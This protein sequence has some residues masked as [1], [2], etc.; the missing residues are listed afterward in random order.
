MK[1]ILLT[2]TA[3][4][5]GMVGL[6]NAN[7]ITFSGNVAD[8]EGV[9]SIDYI[10]FDVTEAG[11]FNFE[12]DAP[13]FDSHLYLFS[14]DGSLDNGD[15]IAVNDDNGEGP[16]YDR[17]TNSRISQSLLSVG[18]YVTAVGDYH[19]ARSEA[20]SGTNNQDWWEGSVSGGDYTLTVSSRNGTASTPVPEP[21][22]MLVMGLGLAGLVGYNRKRSSKK[23]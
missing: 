13:T 16:W 17:D 15:Y 12:T 20:I 22:T 23:A 3:L 10:F 4:I 6:A 8:N 2:A 14:W 5:F 7:I 18:S 19:V 11:W 1:K 9:G 21:A